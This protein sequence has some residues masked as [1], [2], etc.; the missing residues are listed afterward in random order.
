MKLR[1][2][3]KN[4]IILSSV[5]FVILAGAGGYLL[6]R[7]NST[8]TLSEQL[9]EAGYITTT[10]PIT[11]R[12][13]VTD[14]ETGI[15][16]TV[17]ANNDYNTATGM[18]QNCAENEI[19]YQCGNALCCRPYVASESSSV[20]STVCGN[21]TCESGETLASCPAD[22]STCGRWSMYRL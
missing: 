21:G 4:S 3:K 18:D 2:S 19:G 16:R 13:T 14:T 12:V 8:N 22:C 15:T 10:N 9:T 6:W 1:L 11:G 7:V 5:F 17:V 20:A